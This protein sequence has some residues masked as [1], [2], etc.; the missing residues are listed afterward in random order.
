MIGSVRILAV[1]ILVLGFMGIS[2][3]QAA[4]QETLA[5]PKTE[6]AAAAPARGAIFF[7]RQQVEEGFAKGATLFDFSPE[8]NYKVITGRRTSPGQVEVHTN[9]TD[10][11]YVVEGSFTMVTGGTM[12]DPKNQSPTEI[13]ATSVTGGEARQMSKGD[14]IIIPKGTPHWM[15]KVDGTVLYL[16]IKTR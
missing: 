6:T 9:D 7:S 5:T 2:G 11:T 16:V 15:Q 10:I 4:K 3:A 8:H 1:C 13:R 14:L 12:V